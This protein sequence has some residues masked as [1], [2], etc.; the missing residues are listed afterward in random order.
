MTMSGTAAIGHSHPVDRNGHLFRI[1]HVAAD[2][3]RVSAV[4]F[5]LDMSEV[6]LR[7]AACDQAPGARQELRTRWRT[8]CR[9]RGLRLSP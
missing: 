5:D 4:L 8:A 9:F 6:K 7:F 2:S 3:K 1:V